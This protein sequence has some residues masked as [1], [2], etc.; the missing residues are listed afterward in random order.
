MSQYYYNPF[1]SSDVNEA[2]QREYNRQ[3]RIK[4]EKHEIRMM[5]LSMGCAIIAYLV[6]QL[7]VSSLLVPL[8]LYDLYLSNPVF[9]YGFTVLAVSFLSVAVPFGIMALVNRKNYTAPIIPNQRLKASKAFIWICF[10]ML[11]C[12]AANIVVSLVITF[13]EGLF[14]LKFNGGEITEPDSVFACVM[15]L[16]G[17][18]IIPAICEE[19][20]MRCF[21]LQLLRKYGKGFGVVAVSIVFGLLHGN[22]VQFIFAFIIGLVLG[23]V[24]VRTDSIVPAI[25]IH[26]LNNGMSVVQSVVNY[27]AGEEIANTVTVLM[28]L[29]WVAVGIFSGIYLLVKRELFFRDNNNNSVLTT[30]QKFTAFL[31]PWML[32]PMATLIILTLATI[33]K[34]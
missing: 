1:G 33:D 29:L 9:Q 16:V 3:L 5:S 18:S 21:S 8:G 2:M 27:A 31:F 11:C 20:A 23:Y 26:A 6:I 24:T 10:G 19:L 13:F 22:V 7:S 30:G 12:V 25:F 17:V 32:I 28:Y 14:G 15:Y 34:V 4:Q